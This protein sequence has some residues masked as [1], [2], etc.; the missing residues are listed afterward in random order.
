MLA[1]LRTGDVPQLQPHHRLVIPIEHFEGEVHTNG[2]AVVLGEDLVHVALDDRSLPDPQVADDQNFEQPL[3]LHRCCDQ[4]TL[5]T[6]RA[7][8]SG[9]VTQRIL[10]WKVQVMCGANTSGTTEQNKISPVWGFSC[11]TLRCYYDL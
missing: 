4:K 2:G 3:V 8:V 7:Q 1:L 5:G 11:L 10:P 9:C 6:A